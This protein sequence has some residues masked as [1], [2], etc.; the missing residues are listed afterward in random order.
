MFF[1]VIVSFA[2]LS[3]SPVGYIHDEASGTIADVDDFWTVP[4]RQY[5]ILGDD[6]VRTSDLRAF[7][8]HQGMVEAIPTSK[9]EIS[10]VKNP[11]ATRPADPLPI[12][13]GQYRLIASIVGT[14]RK[15]II[16]NYGG[17]TAQYSIE[18]RNPD[19]SVDPGD[20]GSNAGSGLGVIWR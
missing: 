6:F 13:N 10:M 14:G 11:D 5:Y 18:V 19:G 9:V 12:A 15:Q 3:C 17:R 7:A 1:I 20:S 16:V 2:V 4:Q 8:S